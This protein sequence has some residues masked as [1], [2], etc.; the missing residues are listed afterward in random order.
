MRLS[1]KL[2]LQKLAGLAGM[3]HS[4]LQ[5][6]EIGTYQLG[7]DDAEILA[8]AMG[9]DVVE[10]LHSTAQPRDDQERELLEAFRKL[11][12]E[13]RSHAVKIVRALAE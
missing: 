13:V 7:V 10:L 11:P 1:K 6:K 12:V 4:S 3:S 2:S 8:K 9:V 5:K